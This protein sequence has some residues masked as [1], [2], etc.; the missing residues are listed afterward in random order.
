MTE[1]NTDGVPRLRVHAQPKAK[2]HLLETQPPLIEGGVI[3]ER[4]TTRHGVV[5]ERH[6]IPGGPVQWY[7]ET[8]ASKQAAQ[9]EDFNLTAPPL[10]AYVVVAAAPIQVTIHHTS[11]GFDVRAKDAGFEPETIEADILSFPAALARAQEYLSEK[12][13]T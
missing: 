8:P 11:T 10:G 1:L 13:S 3:V 7:K 12:N 5:F 2:L 9:P 4:Y 6:S